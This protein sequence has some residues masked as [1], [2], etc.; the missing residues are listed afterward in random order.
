MK[1]DTILENSTQMNE[2]TI[3]ESNTAESS[4]D[5]AESENYADGQ[6]AEAYQQPEKKDT[7]WTKVAVGGGSAILL[8]TAAALFSTTDAFGKIKELIGI[9]PD[10]KPGDGGGTGGG[11]T[12]GGDDTKTETTTEPKTE[13]TPQE[14][15]TQPEQP[16]VVEHHHHT[17]VHHVHPQTHT[18]YLKEVG[19]DLSF[20]EAFEAARAERGPGGIF[21]WEGKVYSTYYAEEWEAMTPTERAEFIAGVREAVPTDVVGPHNEES[22]YPEPNPNP[23]PDPGPESDPDDEPDPTPTSDD[24]EV[25]RVGP[26]VIDKQTQE[27]FE[28]EGVKV[29]G[30]GD[31]DGHLV[32]GYDST[33]NGN[34][35][36]VI[37]DMDDNHRISNPDI[38]IDDQGNQFTHEQLVNEVQDGLT[39]GEQD[40]ADMGT[41]NGGYRSQYREVSSDEGSS[42]DD[43]AYARN[44]EVNVVDDNQTGGQ[45][46]MVEYYPEESEAGYDSNDGQL[47]ADGDDDGQT[48]DSSDDY[49]DDLYYTDNSYDDVAGGTD[50]IPTYDL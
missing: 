3:L 12:G 25:I 20:S 22:G 32:V 37:V 38:Y 26:H 47:Y 40:G 5:F 15:P 21:I 27:N 13:T 11:N 44:D 50:D 42:N 48:T 31:K 14:Q 24:D 36:L 45:D 30:Y 10:K 7:T 43:V 2:E 39:G 17:Y 34:P 4:N 9:D 46:D 18:P 6:S 8:G 16:T 49:S 23:M 19:S 41:V 33:G 1:E 35:D 29:V 28:V